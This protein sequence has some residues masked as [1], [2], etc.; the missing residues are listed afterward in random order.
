MI[1]H[2]GEGAI[3]ADKD[4]DNVKGNLCEIVES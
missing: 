4:C 3:K 2:D 1:I